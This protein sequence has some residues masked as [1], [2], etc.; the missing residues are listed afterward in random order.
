MTMAEEKKI[1]FQIASLQRTRPSNVYIDRTEHIDDRQRKVFATIK[2]YRSAVNLD[3]NIK[4]IPLSDIKS[5]GGKSFKRRHKFFV[6]KFT[7][8]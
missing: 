5:I 1:R 4:N 8:K 3:G 2:D 7:K 6:G